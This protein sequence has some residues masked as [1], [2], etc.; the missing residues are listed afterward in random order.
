MPPVVAAFRALP[1]VLT[2]PDATACG[3]SVRL[4][5]VL[6][7]FAFPCLQKTRHGSLLNKTPRLRRERS[8]LKPSSQAASCGLVTT[9][10]S[11]HCPR[12]KED[13]FAWPRN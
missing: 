9:V 13:T 12:N 4:L 1:P 7:L 3:A 8:T 10:R 6:T 5:P 2:D 11:M